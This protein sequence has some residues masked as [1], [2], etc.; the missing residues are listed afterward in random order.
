MVLKLKVNTFYG[1]PVD[2]YIP[3]MEFGGKLRT[4]GRCG[5]AFWPKAIGKPRFFANL[6]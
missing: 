3:E 5:P 6:E 4:T 1:K 2:N